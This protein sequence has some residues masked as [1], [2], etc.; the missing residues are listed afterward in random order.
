MKGKAII[1]LV[2]GLAIGLVAVKMAINT[3]RKAQAAGTNTESV[4]VVRATRDI[5]PFERLTAESVELVETKENLFISARDRIETVE[6][7]IGRVTSNAIRENSPVLRPMLAPEGTTA[8]MVGRIPEG[9]RAVSVQIDEVTAVAYQIQPGDWVDLI[10]VMDVATPLGGRKTIAEVILQRIQVA[11]IGDTTTPMT[12]QGSSKVRPARSIT[13]FV[14][15][16]D[17]PKLHLA[18]TQ[19]KITL[20]MRGDDPVIEGQPRSAD[21]SD[22]MSFLRDQEGP[23]VASNE[24]PDWMKGFQRQG[25]TPPRPAVEKPVEPPMPHVVAVYSLSGSDP[26]RSVSRITFENKG[27]SKII[28]VDYGPPTGRM[29]K[30]GKPNRGQGSGQSGREN[31]ATPQG[32]GG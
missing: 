26:V 6:E 32:E 3:I 30:M 29:M 28:D 11:A 25:P 8:G 23:E 19:G 18:S 13:L 20:A 5:K 17:V 4:N 27:S 9:F 7:V 15:E 10:V 14:L 24:L 31:S 16:E 21:M 2:A 12:G 22:V 1:P